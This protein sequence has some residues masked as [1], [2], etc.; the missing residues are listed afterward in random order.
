MSQGMPPVDVRLAI[1]ILILGCPKS[2]TY[3][4]T[5]RVAGPDA[6]TLK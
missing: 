3:S 4:S 1:S 6:L 5:A 2:R